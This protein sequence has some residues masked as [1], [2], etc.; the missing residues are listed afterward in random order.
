MQLMKLIIG[1]LV[2][3]SALV[4]GLLTAS[5]KTAYE[6]TGRNRQEYALQLTQLDQCLRDYGPEGDAAR[7]DIKSY[8]AGVIASVWPSEAAPTGVDYPDPSGQQRLGVNPALAGLIHHAGVEIMRFSSADP[9]RSRVAADCRQDYRDVLRARL[10]VIEDVREQSTGPFYRI[11]VFWLMVVFASFGLS[12]PR[13]SFS[14]LGI[15]LCAASLSTV[16]FLVVDL[17]LQR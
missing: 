13:H 4:L 6:M 2:S 10:T 1:M 12:T 5:V 15:C 14:V 16:I 8:T 11:L 9:V 3:F 17:I 7:A